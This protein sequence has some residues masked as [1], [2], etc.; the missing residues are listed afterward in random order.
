MIHCKEFPFEETSQWKDI[1]ESGSTGTFF[2]T[3]D[4]L[5]LWVRHFGGNPRLLGISDGEE[6]IG[7]VPLSFSN[8]VPRFL[9]TSHV[10]GAEYVTDFGDVVSIPGREGEVWDALGK[11]VNGGME[12]DFIRED[13]P[14][15]PIL[16]SRATGKEIDVAPYVALPLSWDVYLSSLGRKDRHEL[17]RKIRRLE[18]SQAFKI[19]YE[20]D[21][22]DIDEFFRLMVLS[23]EQKRD[24]LSLKMRNF[25]SDIFSTFFPKKQLFL[26]FMKIEGK[27]IAAIVY[28]LF[29]NQ[30]L[31]YNSGF[32]PAFSHLAPGYLLK[33]FAIKHA[34][35]ERR[36]RFDFLRGNER[37]KFDLGAQTRKLYRFTL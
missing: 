11:Y 1:L 28:F 24:F 23:N 13:S 15:F 18:E 36:E 17:K 20:G 5:S 10:S 27:N 30:I 19:C 35:K 14:S 12:A 2:Q 6:L 33:A 7:L 9:G 37:Y 8:T 29:K 25:F 3:F 21:P 26:C 22:T 31:L 4:W 34:I 16:Q 32:D